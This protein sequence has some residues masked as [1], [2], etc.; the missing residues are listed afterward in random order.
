MSR[1]EIHTTDAIAWCR[2][3]GLIIV[4]FNLELLI[5]VGETARVAILARNPKGHFLAVSPIPDRRGAG[6]RDH[7]PQHRGR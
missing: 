3:Q 2:A 7:Q 6:S 4:G 1:A 5:K